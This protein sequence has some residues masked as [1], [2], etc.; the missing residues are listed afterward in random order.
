MPGCFTP[1]EIHAAW[2]AGADMVKVFPATSLG[3]AFFADVLAPM[4][5]LRLMPTGG[6]TR[7]NAGAW[8]RAGAVA[9]GVGSALVDKAA[10]REGRWADHHRRGPAVRRGRRGGARPGRGEGGG[11]M[12]A[13]CFGEIMLRL[14]PPG[15]ERFFQSPALQA[16]FG[17]GEAN[18]AVSLAHFG[19]DSHY[20]TR[21]PAN[22]IG[23]AALRA[24]R[25]EGV[26]VDHV[27]RGG[28]R[29]GIY[30]AE[31]GASQRAS[32]VIYDRAHSAV[33]E[34]APGAVNWACV[35]QGAGWFHWTGITP[36]LG[37][38]VA[39]CVGE[40]IEAAR[41]A[42]AARERGPQLPPQAVERGRSA[43]G[44]A[45]AGAGRRPGHRQRRGPAGGARRGGQR[46]RRHPRRARRR[47]LSRGLR[48][49]SPASS[50]SPGWR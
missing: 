10:V 36:A 48:Q 42:G 49:R 40:A 14:S 38:A 9:I 17:G 31:S 46:R 39:G 26:K 33:S 8:I 15:L 25:A 22:P 5:R 2:Q 18:V 45:P 1:T 4:P 23:D 20:V 19:C 44:D 37:S 30:F 41:A 43:A 47:R 32:T 12:K 27:L 13:V 24:L 21:L 7:E 35:M 11:A 6:V 16:S 28:S 29:L 3:P 34:L 50:M